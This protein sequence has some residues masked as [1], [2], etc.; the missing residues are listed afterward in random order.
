MEEMAPPRLSKVARRWAIL[1]H[2]RGAQGTGTITAL[3]HQFAVSEMTIRRDVQMLVHQGLVSI[4]GGD[5]RLTPSTTVTEEVYHF[6]LASH[7]TVKT[8]IAAAAKTLIH[9]NMTVFLDGG[10]TVGA[11]AP[12]LMPMK[13]L[14]V[15][16]NALN[17]MNVLSSNG[18]MRLIG[19]GGTLRASSLT[20]LGPKANA[21]IRELRADIAFIGTDSFSVGTGLEVPDE[22]DAAFKEA[23]IRSSKM[24]VVLATSD[25]CDQMRLYQFAD[26]RAIDYLITDH[27]LP[28]ATA[29]A[30]TEW[31]VTVTRVDT[32]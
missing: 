8:A 15:I 13:R 7:P 23:V 12:L 2:L 14:T 22:A 31:G 17:I 10:T 9:E 32:P 27:D 30:L 25:K 19:I 1:D 3:S 5:I 28:E 6:K 29:Q 11:L 4:V 20:F 26:W 18:G 16:T 21:L 24:S